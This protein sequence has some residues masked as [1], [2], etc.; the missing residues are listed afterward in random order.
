MPESQRI[1]FALCDLASAGGLQWPPPVDHLVAIEAKCAYFNADQYR[2][3]STKSS[4]SK[5]REVRLQLDELFEMVPFNR[6]A[7]LDFI[8][9]PPAI[10]GDGSAWLHA[11]ANAASA[12]DEMRE[13]LEARLPTDSPAGHFVLS[14]GAVHG[15][16]EL[17]RGTGSPQ[18]LRA[19]AENP[20]LRES[21]VQKRRREM[22]D[23]LRRIL[24]QRPQPL[25]FP[26][27][28]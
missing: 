3:M 11:A 14:W 24:A 4:P 13:I 5:T 10:G 25:Y 21:D 23:N 2:V 26:A 28:L 15:G 6:V 17:W 18:Q 7:L 19:T 22:E 8:I 1:Y 20:Q 9:N 27:I 12:V 16:T